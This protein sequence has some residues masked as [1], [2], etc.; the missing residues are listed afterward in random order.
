HMAWLS[1]TLGRCLCL[2]PERS[3]SRCS[4]VGSRQ[5][6]QPLTAFPV[7]DSA[8]ADGLENACPLTHSPSATTSAVAPRYRRPPQYK[9]VR[10]G[11]LPDLISDS[12]SSDM[13]G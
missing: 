11:S 12:R 4:P 1:M 9:V 3:V 2:C 6:F 10:T 5:N 13:G 7:I 8:A